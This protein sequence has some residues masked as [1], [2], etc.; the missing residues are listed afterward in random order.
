M[1]MLVKFKVNHFVPQNI[2]HNT[3]P[4]CRGDQTE[5]I[6]GTLYILAPTKAPS[7]PPNPPLDVG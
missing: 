2:F 3:G 6:L 4:L 1:G 5:L 7:K